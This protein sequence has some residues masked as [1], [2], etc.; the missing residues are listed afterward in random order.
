MDNNK[1]VILSK[2]PKCISNS[3]TELEQLKQQNEELLSC[4][5][6]YMKKQLK[7]FSKTGY[8]KYLTLFKS[9]NSKQIKLIEKHKG[10]PIA[11]V[12]GND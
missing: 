11:E 1:K 6:D 7:E 3:S 9:S 2:C 5:I 8:V 12:L 10:K 4:L